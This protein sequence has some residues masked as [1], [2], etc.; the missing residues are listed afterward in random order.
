M[1]VERVDIGTATLYLGDCREV[2]PTLGHV[3]AVIMDPPYGV[4]LKAKR[5]KQR[6]GGVKV[7]AGQYGHEDSPAYVRTVVIDAL[8]RCR[9]LAPAVTV[10]PGIRN[11]WLYPPADDLGCFFSAAG[12]GL[13][14]WGF[15]CMQPILY[16][17]KDPYLAQCMG[18]RPNSHG[19]TYPNDANTQ[20]HP[21]AKPL[22]MMLWLV[23][24]ASLEGMT[25]LDP[26]MGSGT[27]GVACVRLGRPFIGCE[28]ER[29]YFD[30]ACERLIRETR[31]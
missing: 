16:Y 10:T 15:T 5:A 27:T 26:F 29:R 21:C 31:P 7:R 13:G 2:L 4:Q 11:L 24:R 19:Q 17:G 12:T 1:S 30:V 3:D 22:P 14:R 18:S 23:S 20:A 6:G 9:M 28:I 25:V 8:E